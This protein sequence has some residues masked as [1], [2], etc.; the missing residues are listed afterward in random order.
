MDLDIVPSGSVSL[1][2][3]IDYANTTE[4][5]VGDLI[6]DESSFHPS[7]SHFV[8]GPSFAERDDDKPLAVGQDPLSS[9]VSTNA[10]V[11]SSVAAGRCLLRR[12]PSVV[13]APRYRQI[14]RPRRPGLIRRP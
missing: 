2:A 8:T 4:K 7:P 11:P 1:L 5:S 10:L 14:S 13:P 6:A 12:T 9:I 3:E